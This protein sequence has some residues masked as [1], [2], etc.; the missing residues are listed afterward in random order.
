MLKSGLELDRAFIKKFRMGAKRM[1][2]KKIIKSM[3]KEKIIEFIKANGGM[4]SNSL[5]QER[6]FGDVGIGNK[7]TSAMRKM[8]DE[9]KLKMKITHASNT[10]TIEWLIP[11][12]ENKK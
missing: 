1:A 5:M 2:K 4:V 7:T 10:T 8:A 9:G 12:V 3:S 6:H 11:H